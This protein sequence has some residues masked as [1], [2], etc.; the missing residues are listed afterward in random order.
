MKVHQGLN[1]GEY[2]ISNLPLCFGTEIGRAVTCLSHACKR[3]RNKPTRASQQ[4]HWRSQQCP[5]F[6][7]PRGQSLHY[8]YQHHLL[9]KDDILVFPKKFCCTNHRHGGPFARHR[10]TQVYPGTSSV[11]SLGPTQIS[12]SLRH[13]H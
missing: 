12:I 8:Q 13:P 6:T 9:T 7:S 3:L 11:L 10:N 4:L 5:I 1:L 2:N